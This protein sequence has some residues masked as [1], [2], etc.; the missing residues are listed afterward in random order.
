M[1]DQAFLFV[2]FCCFDFLTGV[3][4]NTNRTRL[5]FDEQN[6]HIPAYIV[7]GY[8][9]DLIAALGIQVDLNLGQTILIQCGAHGTDTVT[10]QNDI[11]VD[12]YRYTV[13]RGIGL[14][15]ETGSTQSGLQMKL[16]GSNALQYSNRLSRILHTG[17]LDHDSVCSLLLHCRLGHA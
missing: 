10:L 4:A 1:T 3:I 7:P 12:V 5:G 15:R 8:A 16:H 11:V 17:Q 6:I 9:V 2:K 14:V 13:G